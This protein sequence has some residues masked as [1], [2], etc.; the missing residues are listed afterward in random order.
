MNV[1][2][3]VSV[4]PSGVLAQ[5]HVLQ[6]AA[7]LQTKPFIIDRWQV[8]EAYRRV[9]ANAGSAGIDQPS[10]A[11]CAMHRKD[12]LYKL[13]N[14]MFSGSYFPSPVKAVAIPKQSGG[15]RV[16]GIP[17]VADRIAQMVVKLEFEPKVEPHFLAD[18]YGYRPRKS[19]LDAI[20]ITRKRC[21]K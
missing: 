8:Y 6:E 2:R 13:W 21:W 19:A 4:K 20:A 17:T 5:L 16:L 12:N 18:A 7:K 11:N 14:R 15:E 9:K 10:L 1:E 3:R